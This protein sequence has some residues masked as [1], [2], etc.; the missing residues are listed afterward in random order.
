MSQI[1]KINILVADDSRTVRHSIIKSLGDDYVIHEAKNGDEAWQL[2][3]STEAISLVFADMHMPAM[4]G[5]LLLKKIRDS[6][7]ERIASLPVIIITGYENADAAK[8]ASHIIG[9]TDFISKP[10]NAS[11]ILSKVGSYTK[12]DRNLLKNKSE[13]INDKLT[14]LL[15]ES[16]FTEYCLSTLEHADNS[17]TDTSLLCMQVIGL[18]DVFKEHGETTS[19]QIIITIANYLDKTLQ[20][21][22]KVAHLGSGRFSIL[23]PATNEFKA[24]I[25]GIRLQ[26][27]VSNLLFEKG[28]AGIRVKAAMGISASNGRDGYQDFNKLHLQAEHALQMSLEQPAVPIVRYDETYEKHCIEEQRAYNTELKEPEDKVVPSDEVLKMKKYFTSIMSG[29]FD[30][31]PAYYVEAMVEPLQNFLEYAYDNTEVEM[32]RPAGSAERKRY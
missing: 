1:T 21:N 25:I 7:C 24:N 28:D 11:T 19:D 27:K 23:L 30:K 13:V 31:V 22:E 15:N 18:S 32:K 12:L 4:N 17:N 5:L 20:D 26:K 16:S 2:L 9:A 8:R 29:D 6:E 3:E 10:F 14:G